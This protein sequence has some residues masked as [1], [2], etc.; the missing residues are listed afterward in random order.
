MCEVGA[1]NTVMPEQRKL[2]DAGGA[3][4]NESGCLD[5]PRILGRR[6]SGA[7][8]RSLAQSPLALFYWPLSS[9]VRGARNGPSKITVQWRGPGLAQLGGQ[10]TALVCIKWQGLEEDYGGST[11]P[12]VFG[13]GFYLTATSELRLGSRRKLSRSF[14]R[15]PR[16]SIHYSQ[17]PNFSSPVRNCNLRWGRVYSRRT[18]LLN[19]LGARL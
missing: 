1:S 9:T 18:L 19:V 14:A 17:S 15:H 3:G 12:H 16:L 10:G 11:G 7:H 2:S 6:S 4:R 8:Q 13:D 5:F